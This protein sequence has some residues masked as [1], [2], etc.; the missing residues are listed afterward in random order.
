MKRLAVVLATV[1]AAIVLI[2]ASRVDQGFY[3][4]PALQMKTV[5]QY[6]AGVSS[7]PNDVVEPGP[8]DVSRDVHQTMVVWAPGTPLAFLP[9]VRAGLTP[10]RAARAVAAIALLAG[11]IGWVLWFAR[12]DLPAPATIAFAIVVPWMRFASNSLFLYSPEVLVFA[13]VPWV[14]LAALAGERVTRAPMLAAAAI[15]ALAGLLYVVKFSATFVTAG[16]FLWFAWR[17]ARNGE[18]A[19]RR[20][21][22]IAV[23]TAAAGIPI[24][25]LSAMNQRAS[26][27]ANLVLASLGGHWRWVYLVHAVG[28]TALTAADLDS[29]LAFLLMHPTHGVT[30][31]VFWLSLAGLPGG[32]LLLLLAARGTQSGAHAELARLLL[33]ASL[34][35]ILIV[36]TLSV[37]V[38][39]EARHLFSA[40]FAMLPLGLAE[41]WA[42]SRTAGAPVRRLIAAAGCVFVAAPLAYG[43][44]SVAAKVRRYPAN[45]RPAASGIYNPLLAP[46]DPASVVDA[47][48]RIYDPATDIWYVTEPL[49]ALDLPGRM[50]VRHVDFTKAEDLSRE[51]FLTLQRVRV[52]ALLPPRFERNGKAAAV[53]DS[54]RQATGWSHAAIAGSE[55]DVWTTVLEPAL[56]GR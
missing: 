27:S 19:V 1:S 29:L 33:L 2:L 20:V 55:Y 7:R 45:Y 53:R 41:G 49:T 9:F 6:L 25:M 17:T 12:F 26:G 13:C 37:T 22:R 42:W 32:V 38:S 43:V 52:H 10:A 18:T 34:G 28:S 39:I 50:I 30:Q 11:S 21:V 23:F 47:L 35:C 40:G 15:G 14:L 54:F 44:V 46:H 4:D 48:R 36:W 56:A 31:D 3:S 8:A 51:R 5:L 16:L 24:V